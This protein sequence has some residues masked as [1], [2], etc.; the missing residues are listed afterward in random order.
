MSYTTNAEEETFVVQSIKGELENDV[1][2]RRD[3]VGL[4]IELP[5]HPDVQDEDMQVPS[6]YGLVKDTRVKISLKNHLNGCQI[7][8]IVSQNKVG[9]YSVAESGVE[10][11][12][13]KENK[14]AGTT[15][16]V[17]TEDSKIKLKLSF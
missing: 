4:D 7:Q 10:V 15:Q 14:L 11:T 1:Y 12:Q 16:T 6:S 8:D 2:Q 17:G 13:K 9:L 5:N 3:E